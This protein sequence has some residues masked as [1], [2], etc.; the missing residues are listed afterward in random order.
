MS[1]AISS[2]HVGTHSS[3]SEICAV[4]ADCSGSMATIKNI[5]FMSGTS[6][7]IPEPD[8][9]DNEPQPDPTLIIMEEAS[10]YISDCWEGCTECRKA[11]YDNDPNYIFGHCVNDIVY[12][13]GNQCNSSQDRSRCSTMEMDFCFRAYPADSD[14]RW[15][16]P[17]NKCRSLIEFNRDLT[18][19]W[20]Y[21]SKNTSNLN[22]GMCI[23]DND[24][25]L[26]CALSWD[27][28]DPAGNKGYTSMYRPRP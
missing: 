5:E 17:D 6:E 1:L 19:P 16:D 26:Q 24:P 8:E 23:L 2:Y 18:F 12:R 20:L 10:N 22:R 21:K 27:S 3:I 7:I 11:Y 13:Y 4:Q 28:N 15:K 25:Y 14:L 9:N